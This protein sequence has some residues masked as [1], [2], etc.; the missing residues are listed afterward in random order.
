MADE[1]TN[2]WRAHFHTIEVDDPNPLAGDLFKRRFGHDIPDY[3]RHFVLMYDD[4]A[5]SDRR[6][7]AYVHQMPHNEV[8][9]GGGMCVDESAYRAFPKW[10]FA[11]VRREGGLAT[12]V[13][14]DSIALLGDSPAAFG[15]VGEPRAR[16]AD[17]RT[18][19][20]DTGR[21]HLMV[22]WRKELP[23]AEKARLIEMVDAFGAF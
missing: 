12:I 21:P 13:T 7:V 5:G 20:V 6:A 1:S 4:L 16:E 18:G 22:F 15:H 3:P 11:E 14:R 17:L 19:Y 8:Y 23:A 10:L 2:N 9:L